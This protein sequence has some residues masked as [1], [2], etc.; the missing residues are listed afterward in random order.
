VVEL[1]TANG[2]SGIWFA[3]ALQATDGELTTFEIDPQRAKQAR[4]N[5]KEPASIT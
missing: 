2:Y 5:L 3:L 4:E 1:G